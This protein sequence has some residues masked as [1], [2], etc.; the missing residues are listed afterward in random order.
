MAM[1]TPSPSDNTV[2][3]STTAVAGSGETLPMAANTIRD[4]T[5]DRT[6]YAYD[7]NGEY[8]RSGNSR[9][10]MLPK[11]EQARS[12]SYHNTHGKPTVFEQVNRGEGKP[13][14]RSESHHE[15]S[16][17][18]DE[19]LT[20][21]EDWRG[22]HTRQQT[23]QHPSTSSSSQSARQLVHLPPI[24][25]QPPS[26]FYENGYSGPNGSG[27]RQRTHSTP[28][29]LQLQ[30]VLN[31][32]PSPTSTTASTSASKSFYPG[33]KVTFIDIQGF[34]Y[35]PRRADDGQQLHLQQT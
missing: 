11:T 16:S 1:G 19:Q 12:R 33:S 17:P 32:T 21:Q 29:P 18:Q 34:E 13:S 6:T 24:R 15:R 28:H 3:L 31:S 26:S 9:S 35:Q 7:T 27:A 4:H 23:N 10:E 20:G 25:T 2:T 14:I 5:Q 22:E 30:H 8:N